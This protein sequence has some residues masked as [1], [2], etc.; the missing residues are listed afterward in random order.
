MV[1]DGQVRRLH[2]ELDSGISLA[3]AARRTGMSNKT[4]RHV[5]RWMTFE[6][7]GLVT[8]LGAEGSRRCSP[9]KAPGLGAVLRKRNDGSRVTVDG[10]FFRHF[11]APRD[12]SATG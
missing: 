2:R 3:S 9:R 6:N 8:G 1:T 5:S 12:G 4:A 11:R 7:H 10:G